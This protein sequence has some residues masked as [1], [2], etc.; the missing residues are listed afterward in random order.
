[1]AIDMLLDATVEN[2]PSGF[3]FDGTRRP[4]VGEWLT[5]GP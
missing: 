3:P 4:V 1:M 5:T 2:F